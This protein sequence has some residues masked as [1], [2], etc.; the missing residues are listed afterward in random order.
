[1]RRVPAARSVTRPAALSTFRCCETAG[2]LTGSSRA[3][4]PTELG[5]SA[6]FSNTARRV[7]SPR[8]VKGDKR[9]AIAYGKPTLTIPMVSRRSNADLERRKRPADTWYGQEMLNA[10]IDI[11]QG[12]DGE[13][14]VLACFDL[15]EQQIAASA[16]AVAATA[17]ERFRSAAMS[18]DDVLAF[19]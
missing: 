3:R 19:R 8:A 4:P 18:V 17:G 1:M 9:L 6:S 11:S 2:R 12:L 10:R 5:R 13:P 16:Y 15:G 7:G 14:V